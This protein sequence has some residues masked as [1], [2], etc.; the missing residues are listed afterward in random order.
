M[1]NITIYQL[2]VQ[3]DFLTRSWKLHGFVGSDFSEFVHSERL[4]HTDCI[5][6]FGSVYLDGLDD[7]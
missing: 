2:K 5:G 3:D 7:V 4:D 6:M 1:V